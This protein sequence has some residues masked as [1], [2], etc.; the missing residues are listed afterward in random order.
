MG[1]ERHAGTEADSLP[2]GTQRM[3]ELARALA[4]GP[5]LLLLDEASSGVSSVESAEMAS[6]LRRL[7]DDGLTIVLVEHDMTFVMGLCERI[8][9]LD[10]GVLAADGTP[11]DIQRDPAVQAAYLGS[12]A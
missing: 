7:A 8:V 6:V 4:S 9:M 1:L 11:E 2:T 3:V 10:H 5:R 12:V